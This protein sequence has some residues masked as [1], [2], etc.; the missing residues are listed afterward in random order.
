MVVLLPNATIFN[1]VVMLTIALDYSFYVKLFLINVKSK[2]TKARNIFY[3]MYI[4]NSKIK[5]CPYMIDEHNA[6]LYLTKK[7]PK[8]WLTLLTAV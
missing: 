5:F 8:F 4:T 2:K 6:F 7:Y 1:S 3:G